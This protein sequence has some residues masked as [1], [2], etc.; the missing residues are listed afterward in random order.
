MD[1]DDRAIPFSYKIIYDLTK[2]ITKE[3]SKILIDI[4]HNVSDTKT[5]FYVGGFCNSKMV[6]DSIRENIDKE[7]PN[8]NHIRPND[9]GNAVLKGAVMY[10]ISPDRIKS[11]KAKYSLGMSACLD[12]KSDYENGGIPYYDDEFKKNVCKHAF[13]NFISKEE[14][15]PYDNIIK[16]PLRLR[17]YDDGRYGGELRIYKSTKINTLFIDEDSVEEIGRFNILIDD[18]NE[19]SDGDEIFYVSKELGVTFLNAKAFHEKSNTCEEIKF[20][21]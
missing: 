9:P 3:I 19:Y 11:R 15:I 13:Y 2:D 4:I 6:V 10:G 7:Y 14:D 18:G 16:K 1:E 8:L 21:Y 20:K 17:K 12:W 5:I